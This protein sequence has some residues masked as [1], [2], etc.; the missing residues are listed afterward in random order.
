MYPTKK[1]WKELLKHKRII[2]IMF[3]NDKIEEYSNVDGQIKIKLINNFNEEWGKNTHYTD[4][5]IK[6]TWIFPDILYVLSDRNRFIGSVAI[7]CHY[8]LPVISHLYVEERYRK[9]GI[10]PKLL[11]YAENHC[12]SVGY[13]NIYGFCEDFRV[14]YYK[15]FGWSVVKWNFICRGVLGKTLMYKTF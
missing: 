11:K 3:S 9:N 7:D 10:G 14:N 1:W 5:F 6:R 4:Q 2:R 12:R 8:I 13:K 15:K